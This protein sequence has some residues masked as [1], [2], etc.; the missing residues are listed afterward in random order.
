MEVKC[1]RC[2]FRFDMPLTPG[3]NQLQCF[4]P[5]CGMPFSYDLTD[6]PDAEELQGATDQPSASNPTPPPTPVSSAHPR[7][8]QS[9]MRSGNNASAPSGNGREGGPWHGGDRYA[10]FD[11]WQPWPHRPQRPSGASPRGG[12]MVPPPPP[13]PEGK[14][15][16]CWHRLWVAAL[17]CAV[18]GVLVVRYCESQDQYVAPD[19]NVADAP[20]RQGAPRDYVAHADDAPTDS[21]PEGVAEMDEQVPEWVEGT[22]HAATDYGGI[23]VTVEGKTISETTDGETC[24]G[25]F[26]YHDDALYCDFG[27]DNVF[28]YRLYP[29]KHCIDAGNG[30]LMEKVE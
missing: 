16:G 15:K 24:R 14:K 7:S 10:P 26:I 30:I 9:N 6:A 13:T 19:M 29:H 21:L 17:F 11:D 12:Q 25:T 27:D 8:V 22:W 23:T 18:V 3:V 20:N 2:R 28:V 1:P 4:C 5:R